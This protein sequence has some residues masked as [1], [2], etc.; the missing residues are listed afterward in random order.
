MLNDLN[1]LS[2]VRA[3]KISLKGREKLGLVTGV[4]KKPSLSL[5]PTTKD[6]KAQEQ[7]EMQDQK[8]IS[9]LVT[10]TEPHIAEMCTYQET[11]TEL[12]EHLQETYDQNQN[13]SHIYNLKHELQQIK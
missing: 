6:I 12:W 5:V 7:W 4:I 13:F 9:W 3:V 8:V 2:W 10:S 11:T 1:Y